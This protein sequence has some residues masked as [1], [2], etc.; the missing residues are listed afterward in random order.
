MKSG[1]PRYV[2]RRRRIAVATPEWGRGCKQS[3]DF[4]H[5]LGIV[6]PTLALRC[7]FADFVQPE[8]IARVPP[9]PCGVTTA[10]LYSERLPK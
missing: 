5:L 8:G 1:R 4:H 6:V 9:C 2:E 7:L 3:R 10:A